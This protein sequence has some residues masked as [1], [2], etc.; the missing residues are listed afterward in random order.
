MTAMKNSAD[1]TGCCI[2]CKREFQF[3][4]VVLNEWMACPNCSKETMC[5]RS[6][7][8]VVRKWLA[9]GVLGVV[10]LVVVIGGVA[11]LAVAARD[12]GKT[13]DLGATKQKSK[14]VISVRVGKTFSALQIRND[15]AFEWQSAKVYVNGIVMGYSAEIGSVARGETITVNL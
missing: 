13:G 11:L 7:V 8:V 14:G 3:S 2:W 4:K 15:D 5:R 6:V 9:I 12:N 10:A 1:L